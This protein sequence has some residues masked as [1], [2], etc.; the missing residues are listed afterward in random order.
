MINGDNQDSFE[1][2]QL[3]Q[4][5]LDRRKHRRVWLPVWDK[6]HAGKQVLHALGKVLAHDTDDL[7]ETGIAERLQNMVKE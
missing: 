5:Y 3:R 1:I 4:T 7:G 2:H 6:R